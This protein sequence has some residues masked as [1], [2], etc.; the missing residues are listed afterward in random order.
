MFAVPEV[1]DDI[2]ASSL[3]ETTNPEVTVESQSSPPPP[4]SVLTGENEEKVPSTAPK[5]HCSRLTH[6]HRNTI[7]VCDQTVEHV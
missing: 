6:F 5:Q 1:D 7:Q 2:N 3:T 4:V